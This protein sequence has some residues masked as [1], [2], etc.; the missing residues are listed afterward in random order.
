[1]NGNLSAEWW[2]IFILVNLFF[3]P[4]DDDK[5]NKQII[6]LKYLLATILDFLLILVR[7]GLWRF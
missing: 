6:L 3:L 5:H 1:M 2:C 7:F 4:L